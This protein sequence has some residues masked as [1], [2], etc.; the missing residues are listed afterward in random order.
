MYAAGNKS[1]VAKLLSKDGEGYL[2]LP[3]PIIERAMTYY[4]EKFYGADG[5]IKHPDW[6]IG[7]IDFQPWPYPSAT[8]LIANAMN[9][10]VVGG[11]TTFL[12]NLDPDF[13]ARDLVNYDFVRN[14]M[15]KYPD[16]KNAPGI[17]PADPFNRTEV[18]AL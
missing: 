13:V 17:D 10:T 16:W 3:A 12:K 18:L 8:K 4:D 6:K 14:A 7:R 15:A 11:D 5:A 1:E 9:E 2:P